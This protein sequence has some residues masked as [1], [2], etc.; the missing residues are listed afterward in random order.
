MTRSLGSA[1]RIGLV[2]VIAAVAFAVGWPVYV[3]LWRHGDDRPLAWEDVTSELR[4]FESS[5]PVGVVIDDRADFAEF[6]RRAMPGRAPALPAIDWRRRRVVLVASGPRSSTGYELRV[7]RVVEERS[8]ILIVVH[9]RTPTL[10]E[11]VVARV[12]YPYRLLT[13][14]ATTKHVALRWQGR[15]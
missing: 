1:A 13:I 14:P 6:L 11:P 5:R 7:V 12:T 2:A 15:S 10:G 4:G 3:H 9:E 8:R